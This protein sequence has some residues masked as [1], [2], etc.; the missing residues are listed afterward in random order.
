MRPALLLVLLA[1]VAQAAAPEALVERGTYVGV[2]V[3]PLGFV[4]PPIARSQVL[5]GYGLSLEVR[6]APWERLAFSVL[7]MS[8][9]MQG[10]AAAQGDVISVT[11][12]LA[13]RLNLLGVSDRFE[14]RR[15]WLYL[16]GGGGYT[17]FWPQ[18][19]M[20]RGAPVLFA[21]LGLEYRTH[22]RHFAVSLEAT[23]NYYPTL[24]LWSFAVTPSL[25]FAF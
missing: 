2:G 19:V 4:N 1:S 8:S 15:L 14:V 10:G 5:V 25:Q 6:Y 16:R 20:T 24:S 9:G 22:L 23:P 21:G 11:P 7:L 17:L 3:G 12:A 18:T 13:V